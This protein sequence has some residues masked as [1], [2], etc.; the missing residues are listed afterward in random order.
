LEGGEGGEGRRRGR[1]EWVGKGGKGRKEGEGIP[2]CLFK[3][4]LE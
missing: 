2:M 1:R 3:F 4:S